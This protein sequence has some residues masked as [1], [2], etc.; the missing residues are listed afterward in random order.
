[1]RVLELEP[2][3]ENGYD[4]HNHHQDMIMRI[5][6]VIK[7]LKVELRRGRRIKWKITNLVGVG[8]LKRE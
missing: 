2:A 6:R 7:N 5:S 1:M 8:R 4:V 3:Y